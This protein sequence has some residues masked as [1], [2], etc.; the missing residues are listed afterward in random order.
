M[1]QKET[2]IDQVF[3]VDE[4]TCLASVNIILAVGPE[5]FHSS[6]GI[7][8]VECVEH[9]TGHASFVKLIGA[10]DIEEL[11]ALSKNRERFLLPPERGPIGQNCFWKRRRD[12]EAASA[13]HKRDHRGTRAHLH[14]TLRPMMHKPMGDRMRRRHSKSAGCRPR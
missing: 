11:E 4:I 3:Y 6:S 2:D 10:E 1:H 8:L 12:S 13:Q 14:H 7:D 5:Q 9:N